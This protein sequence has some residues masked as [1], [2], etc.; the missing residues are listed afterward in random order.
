VIKIKQYLPKRKLCSPPIAM[1]KWRIGQWRE[2]CKGTGR[3]QPTVG[4]AIVSESMVEKDEV[5]KTVE[6][7]AKTL[8]PFA[9]TIVGNPNATIR[10]DQHSPESLK[11]T[12]RLVHRVLVG[13]GSFEGEQPPPIVLEKSLG[14]GGMGV[15]HLA[16]Q[17]SLGRK[18]AVKTLRPEGRQDS[19]TVLK[20]VREAWLTGSLEH[21][22]IV[23][24]YDLGVS[25]TGTPVMVLKRIEGVPWSEVIQKSKLDEGEDYDHFEWN[26]RV[27]MQVCNAVHFAHSRKIIHRDLKPEN[28]MIGE[29]GEVYVL[30]WGLAVSLEPTGEGRLPL[31]A[32]ATGMAGTPGYMAPEMLGGKEPSLSERTDVYLLGAI[33]YEILCGMPPHH[34]TTLM[35]MIHSVVLSIPKFPD[36][37]PME[38]AKI[39][40]KAMEAEQADRYQSAEQLRKAVEHFLHHRGSMRLAD[41]AEKSLGRLLKELEHPETDDIRRLSVYNWLGE[42]RFGY[43]AALD[44]WP[45][46]NLAHEGLKKALEAS[47]EFELKCGDPKAASLLLA[48]IEDPSPALLESIETSRENLAK[49]AKKIEELR[50][51]SDNL[52]P[53]TGAR[54]RMTVFGVFG[55]I[56]IVA[57][58]VA[59]FVEKDNQRLSYNWNVVTSIGFLMLAFVMGLWGKESLSK[60]LLNRRVYATIL[61]VFLGQLMLSLGGYLHGIHAISLRVVQFFFW[62]VILALL[63][64]HVEVWLWP[65]ML[66]SLVIFLVVAQ[67]PQ[68]LWL[69]MSL[70]AFSITV[71][72]VAIWLP[73]SL[74]WP[75]FE[76]RR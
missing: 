22:N 74:P 35:A 60:T 13:T 6:A 8:S 19:S 66:T 38:A 26:L 7:Y 21:P 68:L 57:P 55:T 76:R 49:D 51:L 45:D 75:I 16:T 34:G 54:T 67:W 62:F 50:K 28:V 46:N 48:E 42:C 73:Q 40:Q 58:L 39:C 1:A 71:N 64:I 44:A 17:Y 4:C 31:A 10:P 14:E 59:F 11:Q 52:D 53:A 70:C 63:T 56:W 43:R 5:S 29:F 33:L 9:D 72:V 25:E 61:F 15:V 36:S 20:L 37:V 12:S 27:W 47:A 32:H 65:A 69:A 2:G 18:V 3:R 41:R 24:V 30:D 23:P